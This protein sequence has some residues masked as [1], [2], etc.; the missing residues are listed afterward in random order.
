MRLSLRR[1]D[2]P[3]SR[4]F[5]SQLFARWLSDITAD[6]LARADIFTLPPARYAILFAA[7]AFTP[8]FSQPAAADIDY[9]FRQPL[10]TAITP[11]KL[12]FAS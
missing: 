6:E 2:R 8:D 11:L 1:A 10:P 5:E 4:Y 12:A 3:L 7:A 9:G